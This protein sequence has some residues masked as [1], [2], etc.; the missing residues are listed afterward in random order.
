MQTPLWVPLV[1]AVIGVLGTVAAGVAG[2]LIT[3]RRSDRRDDKTWQRD[4]QRERERWAREDEDRTFEHRRESYVSFYESLKV[5]ALMAYE[6]GYGFHA[7]PE[8][9]RDWN[10]QTFAHLNRLR[11]YGRP[12]VAMAA[13]TAYN[14]AWRWGQYCKHDDLDDPMFHDGQERY[15]EAE[16]KLLLMIREDLGIPGDTEGAVEGLA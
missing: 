8:L 13:A 5:M 6:K 7:E 4:R 11:I 1:V 12:A 3:Q 15:D 2:V 9:P 16:F 10:R 14:A